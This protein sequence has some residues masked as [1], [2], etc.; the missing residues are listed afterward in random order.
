MRTLAAVVVSLMIVVAALHGGLV[1]SCGRTQAPVVWLT[2]P[3]TSGSAL[4]ISPRTATLAIGNSFTFA[5]TVSGA[6]DTSITWQVEEGAEGGTITSAGRYIAPALPGTYHV[7]A[8][9]AANPAQ[10]D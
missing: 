10:F 9:S 4:A 2:D 1:A 3:E 8:R 7:V 6:P 5:V